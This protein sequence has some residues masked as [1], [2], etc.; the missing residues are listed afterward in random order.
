M[1]THVTIMQIHCVE[2]KV[3]VNLW[4]INTGVVDFFGD[5]HSMVGVA[6]NKYA[7]KASGFNRDNHGLVGNNRSGA[8][9]VF[10]RKQI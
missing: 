8:V 7:K 4:V 1:L 3:A 10:K 2:K 9:N 6:T 5:A